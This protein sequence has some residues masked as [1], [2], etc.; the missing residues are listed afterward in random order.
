MIKTYELKYV[1][2]VNSLIIKHIVVNYK[3][4]I[5]VLFLYYSQSVNARDMLICFPQI[6]TDNNNN[7]KFNI[8]IYIIS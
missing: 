5:N 2:N 1:D 8:Y 6:H 3:L 4:I 7:N